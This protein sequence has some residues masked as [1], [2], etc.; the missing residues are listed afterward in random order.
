MNAYYLGFLRSA[1]PSKEVSVEPYSRLQ[2][3]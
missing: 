2:G 1:R 3:T